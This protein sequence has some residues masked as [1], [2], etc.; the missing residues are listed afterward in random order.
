MGLLKTIMFRDSLEIKDA[1]H[2]IDITSSADGKCSAT[3]NCYT[4]RD[5]YL[6]GDSYL[7][8]K[9]VSFSLKYGMSVGSDKNQGYN[10]IKT[11]EDYQD[12]IDVYEEGQAI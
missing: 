5:S 1:Y 12:A 8:Q 11:L 2:R 6:N 4:T 7:T 3:I 9:V 10:Y